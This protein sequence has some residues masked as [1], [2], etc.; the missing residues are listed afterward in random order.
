MNQPGNKKIV[1]MAGR[2]SSTN[3]IFH[4]LDQKV[5]VH[6]VILEES[7]SKKLFLQRRVKKL[8]YFKVAGQLFFLL[9]IVPILRY[10]SARYIKENVLAAGLSEAEIPKEKTMEVSSI[11]SKQVA[12]FLTEIQP[13]VVVINGTRIISKKILSAIKCPVINM[14]AG[15]TPM[16]RGVH[17]GYWAL[18][19]NDME[20]CGVTVHL[21]DEGVD[22]GN[23]L[24][25]EKISVNHTDNF[26]TYP[27]KQ[28]ATGIPLLIMA[29]QNALKNTLSSYERSGNS[30][31]WY[32]P[33]IWEYLYYRIS[34]G[35]K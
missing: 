26:V 9:I 14:H 17:G 20:N 31:Q 10:F 4:G 12:G 1:L 35:I 21:V 22:T 15:I 19:N 29:V 3:I 28:L 7:E 13:D 18:V 24:Y 2:G 16:Y 34:R 33:T 5:G 23:I 30:A 6:T 8:G 25:Q 11:N 27:S 32:H